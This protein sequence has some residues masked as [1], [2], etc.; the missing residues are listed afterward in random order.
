[1]NGWGGRRDG[2]GRG[3][4]RHLDR[5]DLKQMARQGMSRARAAEFL[6]VG[7]GVVDR[8]ARRFG[9]RFASPRFY[10]YVGDRGRFGHEKIVRHPN[11]QATR[12]KKG[13]KLTRR[14]AAA[15]LAAP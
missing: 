14:Q 2:A 5:A 10:G 4:T 1:M 9:I 13:W 8:E 3:R 15:T 12:R 11:Y 7:W 6:G